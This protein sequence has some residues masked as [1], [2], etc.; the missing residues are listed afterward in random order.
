M[1]SIKCPKCS[2]KVSL[3][4]SEDRPRHVWVDF[5]PVDHLKVI[6]CK[7]GKKVVYLKEKSQQRIDE[8]RHWDKF[9]GRDHL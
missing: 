6:S 1:L 5:V 8:A 9:T 4:L 7:C 2:E 3:P